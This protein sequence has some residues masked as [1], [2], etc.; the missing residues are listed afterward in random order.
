MYHLLCQGLFLD[1]FE[2][3]SNVLMVFVYF[4]GN[5]YIH[6][7]LWTLLIKDPL[8]ARL[9]SCMQLYNYCSISWFLSNVRDMLK[10]LYEIWNCKNCAFCWS[11]TGSH[12]VI[13]NYMWNRC[14]D[15]LGCIMIELKMELFMLHCIAWFRSQSWLW[16]W[17]WDKMC[18]FMA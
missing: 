16:K 15:A 11:F 10:K 5:E 6:R 8:F 2:W 9:A 4:F 12:N 3:Q 18:I 7:N 13:S 1:M 17:E 14:W